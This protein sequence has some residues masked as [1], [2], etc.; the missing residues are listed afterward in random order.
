LDADATPRA[1]KVV[2][3]VLKNNELLQHQ[4]CEL[5]QKEQN[6]TIANKLCCGLHK[7]RTAIQENN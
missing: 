1:S 5:L 2:L 4:N 7:L 6:T 3:F